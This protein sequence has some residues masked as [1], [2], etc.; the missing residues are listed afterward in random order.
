MS[1][2]GWFGLP[3]PVGSRFAPQVREGIV[4]S[5]GGARA[6]FQIG[7]LRY[8]YEVVGIHPT[9]MVGTSAGAI[10]VAM[11]A[12]HGDA[13]GQAA[14]VLELEQL[15]LSMESQADMF[16]ERPWYSV[17]RSR[18]AEWASIVRPDARVTR[19]FTLPKLPFPFGRTESAGSPDDPDDPLDGTLDPQAETLAIAQREPAIDASEWTPAMVMQI[20]SALPRLGRAGGD[21]AAIVRGAERTGSMYRPGPLIEQ[22]LAG[23]AYQSSRVE[24][25][26]LEV[27]IGFV[28]LES[29]DLRFMRQDGRIVDRDDVP[30]AGSTHDFSRGV[31]ASCSIPGVFAPVRMDDE[32]YVDGGLRENLPAEMAIGP[33]GVDKAWVIASAPPGVPR[34]ESFAGKSMLSLALRS[35]EILSDEGERDEVAYARSAGAVVIQPE[36]PVHDPLTIDPGLIRINLDYG[37]MRAAEE[38]LSAL[39]SEQTLHQEIIRLRVRA[40]ELERLVLDPASHTEADL[41]ALTRTKYELR[42]RVARTREGILPAGASAWWER[43]EGH[44][45]GV[46]IPPPWLAQP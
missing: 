38:H 19:E 29:G 3:G 42:D 10:L 33:L 25:S 36:V 13:E 31:L 5:G 6:S 14:G 18:G 9:V 26:G 2:R 17:L 16:T 1:R 43:F 37:W 39:A 23:G 20:V 21:L 7:A 46:D 15:W 8:L 30:I 22:L 12:Q 44:P 4:L 27:R 34:A 41:V 11:L 28:A 32:H 40:W 45:G 24:S 35:I